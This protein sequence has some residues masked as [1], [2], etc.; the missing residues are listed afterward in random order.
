MKKMEKK[1]SLADPCVFYKLDANDEL[2]LMVSVTVNDCAVTGLPNDIKWFITNLETCFK[3]TKGRLLS[4]H[5]GIDYEWGV[6]P[7]GKAFVKATMDKKIKN[8][9]KVYEEHIR[10][11]EKIYDMPGKTT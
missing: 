6:L 9:I 1:Q 10:R 5:L 3:I 8:I 2:L 7:N 4:K 11:E